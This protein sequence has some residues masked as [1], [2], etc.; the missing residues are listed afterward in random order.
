MSAR[1]GPRWRWVYAGALVALAAWSALDPE[2][3]RKDLRLRDEVRRMAADNAR[4]AAENARLAREA[5]ALRHDPAAL[6]RAAREELRFVRPG[7]V[8][9][10]LDGD[11]GGAP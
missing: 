2:G 5:E 10:R 3:L 8:V 6:E 1:P 4:L 9:F 11:A 7:E